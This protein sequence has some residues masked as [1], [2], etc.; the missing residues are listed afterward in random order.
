MEKFCVNCEHYRARRGFI[1]IEH[2]CNVRGSM[3]DQIT[4]AK[5]IL[6]DDCADMRRPGTL[7]GPLG[8]LFE[9][10]DGVRVEDE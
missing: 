5:I 3:R 4:G 8:E 9:P 7:C 1:V 2:L 10:K 6:Y